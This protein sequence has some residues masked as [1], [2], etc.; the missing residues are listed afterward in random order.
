ME[1]KSKESYKKQNTRGDK[2][3]YSALA[4]WKYGKPELVTKK[5]DASRRIGGP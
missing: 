2:G 4:K 3:Y 5:E 1:I